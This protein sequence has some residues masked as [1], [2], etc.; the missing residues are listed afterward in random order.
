[1]SIK[2]KKENMKISVERLD[3]LE[4]QTKDKFTKK[5]IEDLKW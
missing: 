4:K 1:M 5:L 2:M 3:E